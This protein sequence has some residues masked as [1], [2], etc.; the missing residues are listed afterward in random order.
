MTAWNPR[1][2]SENS[3]T[4]VLPHFTLSTLT[5]I[6]AHDAVD[7]TSKHR[8]LDPWLMPLFRHIQFQTKIEGC[9]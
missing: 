4:R 2:V 7:H 9:E 1:L 6:T 8:V 5:F 3:Q